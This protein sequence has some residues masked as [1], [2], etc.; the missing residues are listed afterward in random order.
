MKYIEKSAPPESFKQWYE[1][2]QGLVINF[3]YSSLPNPEKSEFHKKLL[4]EQGSI[5]AYTMKRISHDT[6]HIEHIKPRHICLQEAIGLDL[7]YFNLI[8]CFPREGMSSKCRYGAQYKDKWWDNNGNNFISPLNPICETLF[9]FSLDGNIN[10]VD[11]QNEAALTTIRV[12]KLD[13]DQL[14]YDRRL[15]IRSFIFG[16]N[17]T[18]PIDLNFANNAIGNIC[19][20]NQAGMFFEFCIAIRD[21]LKEYLQIF[22]N[23]N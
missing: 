1:T 22:Q 23:I 20:K 3:N 19:N 7:D 6:S 10:L 8:A 4:D 2:Q 9:V 14:S 5:C 21:A 13:D 12:L 18:D 17:G 16:E 11:H 15:A